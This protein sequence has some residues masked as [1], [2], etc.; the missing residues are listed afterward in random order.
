MFSLDGKRCAKH[1]EY[2]KGLSP[3]DL[4]MVASIILRDDAERRY[5]FR[6]S[7]FAIIIL[8]VAEKSPV[9]IW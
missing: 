3:L 8:R 7:Y 1:D 4:D 2:E 5:E 6:R 9:S